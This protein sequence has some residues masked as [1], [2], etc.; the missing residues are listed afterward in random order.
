MKKSFNILI[1]CFI[2][3]SLVTSCERSYY[4]KHEKN[5][6]LS[7]EQVEG[8]KLDEIMDD[9]F[10]EK[11]GDSVIHMETDQHTYY[12]IKNKMI[13]VDKKNHKITRITF[14]SEE[15]KTS[16]GIHLNDSIDKA[17]KTYGDTYYK[18]VEQG[19]DIIG[20]VDHKKDWTLEFWHD[21]KNIFIIRLDLKSME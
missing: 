1:I 18:R 3:Q 2:F 17:I 11:H 8:I 5:T 14:S 16:K 7:Y 15:T 13:A 4:F 6:D 9:K 10:I 12:S 19:T 21:N 20:Y